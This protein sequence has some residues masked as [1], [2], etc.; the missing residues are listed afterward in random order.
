MLIYVFNTR[1]LISGKKLKKFH[2]LV[3]VLVLCI[4]WIGMVDV[5]QNIEP[6]ADKLS[7]VSNWIQLLVNGISMSVTLLG[8]LNIPTCLIQQ[9][10]EKFDAKMRELKLKSWKCKG[11]NLVKEVFAPGKIRTISILNIACCI[12]FLTYKICLEIYVLIIRYKVIC[13]FYWMISFVPSA[14]QTA[15]LCLV[16]NL[17]ISFYYRLKVAHDILIKVDKKYAGIF[18][19]DVSQRTFYRQFKLKI[20]SA[21]QAFS[22]LL[23]LGNVMEKVFGP[24]FLASISSIF[25]VTTI[26]IY[27]CYVLNASSQEESQGYSVW[28]FV[29]SLND[30]LW[31]VG[32]LIFLTTLCEMITFQVSFRFSEC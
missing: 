30:I 29:V 23:N 16:T 7:K 3:V 13:P 24:I 18:V 27:Y 6:S 15:A 26:Q 4:F 20:P 2:L 21:F 22:N 12:L 25:V 1:F 5:L 19:D 11:Q 14:V 8:I 17:L 32:T 31:N 28:T 9:E 10:F